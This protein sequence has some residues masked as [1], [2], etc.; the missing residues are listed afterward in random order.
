M[1]LRPHRRTRLPLESLEARIALSLP[2]GANTYGLTPPAN[3]IDLSLGNATQPGIV[4]ATTVTISPYNLTP[5][6]SSTE[7]G[8]FVQPYDGS[9]IVPRIVAVEENGKRLPVQY[10]RT[11]T[12]RL[13]GQ[14]TNQSVAFFETGKAGTVT[15][16]V[17]GGG[18]STGAYTVE[19]TL[20]GD[21][22]GTGQV[23]LADA[24][25]FAKT[26]AESTG[27]TDYES[28]ADYNQNGLINL[29]DALALE[30]NMPPLTKPNGGWAV[31]NLAPQD[32]IHFSGPTVSGAATLKQNIT[33]DGYTTPGSVVL[34]D[35]KDGTYKFGSQALGTTAKGF[36]TVNA[37]ASGNNA[38]LS[39]YNFKILD[40][41][42]HQ[43][44]RSFPVLWIPFAMPNS[45]Y[46]YVPAKPHR[47]GTGRI[48]ASGVGSSGD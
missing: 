7:F 44:I 24:E 38:G 3:T 35:S 23:T 8:V 31:I 40:P 19:T 4:S 30:R 42:G 48:G 28:S 33:I 37:S 41:F 45:K 47:Y 16:L 5:G 1:A 46:H 2:P 43:Y 17:K 18:L 29:Y 20:P 15:I 13:A 34:V 21:V 39:T 10:G 26:Y 25:A 14:P 36:F 22:L 11:Y 27:Q 32:E 6:K 12:P 9:G